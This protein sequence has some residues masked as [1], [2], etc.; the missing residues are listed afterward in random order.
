MD[1]LPR[2]RPVHPLA[3]GWTVTP[4]QHGSTEQQA[5]GRMPEWPENWQRSYP[6]DPVVFGSV[7]AVRE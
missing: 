4:E 1:F 5:A 7:S 2:R 3:A 6:L